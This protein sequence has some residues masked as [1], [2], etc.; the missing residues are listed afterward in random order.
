VVVSGG[1]AGLAT[2]AALPHRGLECFASG[3]RALSLDP[4]AALELC[5]IGSVRGS[6]ALLGIAKTPPRSP[7]PSQIG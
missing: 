4:L 2:S 6:G 1:P 5:G 3:Y 7:P